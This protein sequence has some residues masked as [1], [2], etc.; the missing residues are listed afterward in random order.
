MRTTTILAVV[1][2]LCFVMHAAPRASADAATLDQMETVCQNWL[3]LMVYQHGAWAGDTTP[4]VRGLD[5]IVVDGRLVGRCFHI[6]PRGYVVVPALMELP[7]VKAYSDTSNLDVYGT[8]GFETM[9]RNELKSRIDS[10]IDQYGSIDT[11]QPQRGQPMLDPG[12][13]QEWNTLLYDPQRFQQ[14]LTGRAAE[15]GPLLTTTWMQDD[16]YNALC[17]NGDGGRTLLG[18]AAISMA[19]IMRFHEWPAQ[20]TNRNGASTDH[21]WDG[22][23]SCDA[24]HSTGAGPLSVD[25]ATPFDYANMP[26]ELT[27]GSS[28]AEKDAV[29]ELC[30]EIAVA[31]EADFGV[32]FTDSQPA[33]APGR[34]KD[35]FDF[36]AFA[37]E[38]TRSGTADPD[39][40]FGYIKDEINVN[41]PIFYRLEDATGKR[42]AFVC[43]GWSDVGGGRK[44]HVNYESH[45]GWVSMDA[46]YCPSGPCGQ[47]DQLMY[48]YNAP[49]KPVEL[50]ISA[51]PM[52]DSYTPP[53]VNGT[54]TITATV[55]DYW[56]QTSVELFIDGV[57][58]AEMTAVD[59]LH[60]EY[61]LDTDPL[62]P[63]IIQLT[64]KVRNQ[65][66]VTTE[67][68]LGIQIIT[69]CNAND[70]HDPNDLAN[71]DGSPWCG[72]CNGNGII[73]E[74]DI[75]DNPA[76]DTDGDGI[77]STCDNCPETANVDQ[78]DTD[79]DTVGDACDNCP[80]H[81]NTDQADADD[82][83]EGDVCDFDVDNDGVLDD[84][85]NCIAT[86]NAD[87]VN[88][89]NDDLGDACDNCPLVGNID[90]TDHDGDT[91][92]DAC[93]NCP[94]FAALD[95]S[96]TDGDGI[97]DPCDTDSDNDGVTNAADNCPLV[98]NPNQEDNERDGIGDLCDDDD[99][100]DTIADTDDNCPLTANATQVDTDLD[101]LGDACD[102]DD[103]ADGVADNID[104]CPL[105]ANTDQADNDDDGEGDVCDTDDDNDGVPDDVDICP[106]AYNPAQTDLDEDGI[107]DE[108]DDDSDG[109]GF[110]DVVD[111]CPTVANPDQADRDDDGL[112]DVCD[113]DNDN[114]GVP[115][116]SDN[117]PFVPNPEQTDYDR[118]GAGD[119]C[120]GDNDN[121]GL[122]NEDDNCPSVYN[123]AQVD[124]DGDGVGNLCDNCVLVENADQADRDGDGVGDACDNCPD[125]ASR[126][127]VD[128]DGDGLGDPCDL[129][130]DNDGVDDNSDNC[131]DVANP[132]QEDV[133]EDG[134]GDA[135]D[136]V[137]DR[138]A[139]PNDGTT[140]ADPNDASTDP[141]DGSEPTKPATT[142][143]LCP[144]VAIAGLGLSI[145][146]LVRR[147]RPRRG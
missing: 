30:Y 5:D 115:D 56:E 16:P 109:D 105:T 36:Y 134:I 40:W 104:N 73:D 84:V 91:I 58:E 147:R 130:S 129:D 90:Q 17:P 69:D 107:G 99:D 4:T 51:T 70:I 123:P 38:R 6:A 83:G 22:D 59:S 141:N 74:C 101:G 124:Q 96:D 45:T 12:N 106:L 118:D 72:D 95:Q 67:E 3:T 19:Q 139:A 78:T 33:N 127:Q 119:A 75:A 76:L 98:V 93:D 113:S 89:D 122:L 18:S 48:N 111:N 116:R 49:N 110:A 121:D 138:P 41:R 32:C 77:I 62:A 66:S 120:D 114:D 92:G 23:N 27:T 86:P 39:T 136:E 108:C 34:F 9:L 140:P 50:T 2:S 102:D 85:D 1:L 128:S 14:R 7:P 42:H 87:Q 47:S 146:G 133:D 53:R 64:V 142:G 117:C 57:K 11:P 125:V 126:V 55:Q 8:A 28:Q 24:G 68:D 21:N 31:L 26:D 100:N 54:V 144:T 137:D 13:R 80:Q 81:A 35:N 43:D 71:C 132:L 63:A 112:G 10:Y 79:S 61:E 97:G 143:G 29:G 94:D 20:G 88:S 82:D 15:V 44:Y 145:V 25:L 60:Y 37:L 52:D 103:D 65:I 46:F 131:P 135:C